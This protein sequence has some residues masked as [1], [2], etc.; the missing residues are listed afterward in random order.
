VHEE[1]VLGLVFLHDAERRRGHAPRNPQRRRKP[2]RESSLPSA[3]VPFEANDIARLETLREFL[4][5]RPC[6]LD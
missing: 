2:L 4:R 6:L 5:E 1:N 3:E